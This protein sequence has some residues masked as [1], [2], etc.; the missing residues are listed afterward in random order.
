MTKKQDYT[1]EEWQLLLDV[2]PMVGLA[3][4]V[5]GKSG[6]GSMKE[7]WAISRG[8]LGGKDG[9]EGNELVHEL[10]DARLKHGE[11]SQVE[12]L[13]NPYRGKSPEEILAEVQEM[14][15]QVRSLLAEK[16]HDDESAG[17]KDWAISVGER[18]ANAAREGGLFDFGGERVS[19]EEAY[20]ID[21]VKKALVS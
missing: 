2:P 6:L 18:V 10:V 9:Y 11:R 14:C 21:A 13:D 15:S 20:V 17:F 12:S 5:A 4:M 16:S 1:N 19:E 7:A 8:V 3:V